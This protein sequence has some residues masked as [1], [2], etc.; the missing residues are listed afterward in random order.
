[1]FLVLLVVRAAPFALPRNRAKRSAA[2]VFLVLLVVRAAP[3]ALPRNRAKRSAAPVFLVLL[4][5]RAAPFAL[6]RNR[7]KRSAAP[8]CSLSYWWRAPHPLRFLGACTFSRR[9]FGFVFWTILAAGRAATPLDLGHPGR[10]PSAPSSPAPSQPFQ[11]HDRLFE[12]LALLPQF[13]QHLIN[14]HS[15]ISRSNLNVGR[16]L[17]GKP[18]TGEQCY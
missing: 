5:V 16:L 1:M 3:F 9:A 17:F 14:V 10:R 6:L 7:A 4:V 11:R 8:N 12:L 13:G 2:P 18:N 15:S